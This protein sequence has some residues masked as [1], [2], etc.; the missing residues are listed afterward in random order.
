MPCKAVQAIPVLQNCIR[1]CSMDTLL[2]QENTENTSEAKLMQYS[3]V[4]SLWEMRFLIMSI[5]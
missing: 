5:S 3:A 1:M 2:V 4:W